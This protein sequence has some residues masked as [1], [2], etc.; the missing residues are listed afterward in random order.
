[1]LL[2][3]THPSHALAYGCWRIYNNHELDAAV[4]CT[5][6]GGDGGGMQNLQLK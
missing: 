5:S 4:K 3:G 6:Q 1:M 2:R